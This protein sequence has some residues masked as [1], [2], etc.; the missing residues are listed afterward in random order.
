MTGITDPSAGPEFAV[1]PNPSKGSF[2]IEASHGINNAEISVHNIIGKV[3][4][5]RSLDINKEETLQLGLQ[6]QPKGLYILSIRSNDFSYNKK[7]IIK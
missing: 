4:Y 5:R 3:V 6:G 7:I 1:Y 2:I